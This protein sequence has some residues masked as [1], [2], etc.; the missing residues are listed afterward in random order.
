[1]TDKQQLEEA[2]E[3]ERDADE[4]E[5]HVDFSQPVPA[6]FPNLKPSTSMPGVAASVDY[7]IF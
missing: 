2:E 1:M 4:L 5:K 3:L 7:L 6:R